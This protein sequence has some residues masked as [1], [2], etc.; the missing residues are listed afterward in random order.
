M[1]SRL[2]L[3]EERDFLAAR[4]GVSSNA[5]ADYRPRYNIAPG[6]EHFI[7]ITGYENREV[8][9]GKWELISAR[10]RWRPEVFD[11]CQS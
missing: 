4:L 2:W 10:A 1:C 7:V 11:Q 9:R 5:L 6:Q 3:A 8:V